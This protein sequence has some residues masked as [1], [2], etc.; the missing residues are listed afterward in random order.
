LK[1]SIEVE[2]EP[3]LKI[4]AEELFVGG[5][6]PVD[7]DRYMILQ[8][9]NSYSLLRSKVFAYQVLTGEGAIVALEQAH[10][11]AMLHED[12]SNATLLNGDLD[13]SDSDKKKN[14]LD[15]KSSSIATIRYVNDGIGTMVS[16]IVVKA[17][18]ASTAITTQAKTTAE[19]LQVYPVYLLIG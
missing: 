13:Q 19:N 2:L 12:K 9:D 8:F 11:T 4:S 14:S 16:S 18:S 3:L 5:R 7:F 15:F 17:Q 1:G 10:N 6:K